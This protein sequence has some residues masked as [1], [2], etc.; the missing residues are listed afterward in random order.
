[1]RRR[2]QLKLPRASMLAFAVAMGVPGCGVDG[3][4]GGMDRQPATLESGG[5]A[6]DRGMEP[7]ASQDAAL[8]SRDLAGHDDKVSGLRNSALR[9]A[10]LR[11]GSQFGYWR[12]AWEILGV[13]ERHSVELSIVFDFNRVSAPAPRGAGHVIPPVV[14]RSF[15]AF[16]SGAGDSVVSVA[17]EYLEIRAPGKLAPVAPNWR[18]YLQLKSRAPD[19]LPKGLLPSN[20]AERARFRDAFGEGWVAGRLQADEEFSRR[21]RRLRRDF[22]G[23]LEYRRLV[24]LGMMNKMVLADADFGVTSSEA[25]MRIGE[26]TVQIVRHSDFQ[27]ESGKWRTAENG[28]LRKP[29]SDRPPE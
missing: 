12:R 4:A 9:E 5:P 23:M 3:Q 29:S 19:D 6:H 8:A 15:H 18:G 28:P 13:L 27:P 21:V 17:D 22:E 7:P 25:T 11:Y 20:D 16:R 14:L 2:L 1:M 26:R 24:A 10:A